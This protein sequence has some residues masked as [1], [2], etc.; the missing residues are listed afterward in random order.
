MRFCEGKMK[1]ESIVGYAGAFACFAYFIVTIGFIITK[2]ASFLIGMEI[3]TIL[4]TPIFLAIF[5]VIPIGGSTEKHIAKDLSVLFMVS[6]MVLTSVAH[7]VNLT[8]TQPLIKSGVNVP[9]YFQIGQWPSVEMAVDYLAWGFFMGLAFL[10]SSFAV[11]KEN[12]RL[13]ILKNTLLI[14][15]L[16]CLAGI[17]GVVLINQSCWYLAP[18]GYGFGTLIVSI[19]LIMLK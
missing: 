13:K 10:S 2:A 7:F 9:T 18:T 4:F 19:E 15:G 17:L 12:K 11:H 3:V 14:C 8:V 6:C 5:A 16:L 1:K